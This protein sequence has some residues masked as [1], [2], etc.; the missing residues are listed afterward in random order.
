M[1]M[2]IGGGMGE[3]VINIIKKQTLSHKPQSHKPHPQS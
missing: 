1:V 2:V 3:I